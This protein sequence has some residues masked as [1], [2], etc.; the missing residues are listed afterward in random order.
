MSPHVFLILRFKRWARHKFVKIVNVDLFGIFVQMTIARFNQDQY[1]WA[2]ARAVFGGMSRPVFLAFFSAYFDENPVDGRIF[3][4]FP[5]NKAKCS[6]W[7][8]PW[9]YL[10]G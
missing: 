8:S 4:Y 3:S 10:G 7:Q 6:M 2:D 9:M 1:K 5:G